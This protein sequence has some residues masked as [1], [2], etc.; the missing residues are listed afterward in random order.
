MKGLWV[1]VLVDVGLVV[2]LGCYFDWRIGTC[3]FVVV[4]ILGGFVC[5][6]RVWAL[7]WMLA[8]WLTLTNLPCR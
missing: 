3:V 2:G 1:R 8:L 6:V 7:G 5:S 4:S